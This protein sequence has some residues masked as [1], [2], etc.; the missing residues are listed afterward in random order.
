LPVL[1]LPLELAL[2]VVELDVVVELEVAPE[3]D[4]EPVVELDVVLDVPPPAPPALVDE[5]A[6]E[7]D[8][9]P[10]PA[11]DLFPPDPQPNAPITKP[12]RTATRFIA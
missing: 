9:A 8:E 5:L 1:V 11:V 3:L 7:P 2:D 12:K 6:V 4:V 10:E